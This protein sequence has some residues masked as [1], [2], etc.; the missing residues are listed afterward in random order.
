MKKKYKRK[1][2]KWWWTIFRLVGVIKQAA[3]VGF[4]WQG[5]HNQQ[6][7][8]A[9]SKK[10]QLRVQ[11][12]FFPENVIR[13][14]NFYFSVLCLSGE[15][16]FQRPFRSTT[17][18]ISDSISKKLHCHWQNKVELCRPDKSLGRLG[19]RC[20]LSKKKTEHH[21]TIGNLLVSFS[22]FK[23]TKKV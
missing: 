17:D 8:T 22:N 2:A 12:L 9:L 3:A 16:F 4:H 13:N 18:T 6:R 15:K 1:N 21:T 19:W 7:L 11:Y 10:C 20:W 23:I 14:V 5:K